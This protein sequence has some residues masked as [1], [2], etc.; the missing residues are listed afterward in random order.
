MNKESALYAVIE[1]E[2][3]EV[4]YGKGMYIY[5]KQGKRYM[6]CAAGIGVVNIGH[7]VKDVMIR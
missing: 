2:Y 3:P 4:D 7:G 1:K 6:D 5:D